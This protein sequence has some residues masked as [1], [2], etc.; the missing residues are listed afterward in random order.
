MVRLL[1]GKMGRKSSKGEASLQT[2]TTGPSHQ[3]E[4][5]SHLKL[6]D[7]P[8]SSGSTPSNRPTSSGHSAAPTPGSNI[9]SQKTKEIQSKVDTATKTMEQNI[10]AA[11][12]RGESLNELQDKTRKIFY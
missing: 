10:H 3:N 1:S 5:D 2:P 11:T 7:V 12:Q 9:D 6:E 4:S 8:V